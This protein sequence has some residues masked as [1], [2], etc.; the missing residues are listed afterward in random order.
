MNEKTRHDETKARANV[1]K[2]RTVA[3]ME[4]VANS[5]EALLDGASKGGRVRAKKLTKKRRIEIARAA[6]N[7]RW[8]NE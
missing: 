1:R 6:A 3:G 7:K 4:D 5:F 8:G 2:L